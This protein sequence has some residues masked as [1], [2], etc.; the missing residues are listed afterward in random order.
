MSRPDSRSR[1]LV[2]GALLV[3]GGLLGAAVPVVHPMKVT[4]YYSHPMTGPSHLLLLAAVLLVSLGLPGLVARQPE[5]LRRW[6]ALGAAGVFVGEWLLDGTHGIVDG[7]VLPAVVHAAHAG[8]VDP[9]PLVT[10][11]Q[12]GPLGVLT[13]LGVPVMILGC[14]TLGVALFRGAA[15]T[16]LPRAAAVLLAACWA[17]FPLRFVFPVVAGADV[18]LP[19]VSLL[20]VG[21]SLWRAPETAPARAVSH[22]TPSPTPA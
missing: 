2:S 1:D 3:T 8:N 22:G 9:V 20:V 19:Y 4:G 7:A 5:A 6:A 15:A 18:A 14:V 21:A 12:N 13:D 11:V 16:R 10:A 17:L